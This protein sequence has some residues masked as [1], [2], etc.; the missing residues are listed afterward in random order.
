[1]GAHLASP[2]RRLGST[3]L[4]TVSAVLLLAA[5]VFISPLGLNDGAEPEPPTAADTT[6]STTATS[7]TT[8]TSPV[9]A[10][11]ST[12]AVTTSTTTV[13]TSST[14]TTAPPTTT[15]T[16]S[17]PAVFLDAAGLGIV[18]LGAPFADA[19]E[20]VTGELGPPTD[21]TGWV[22]AVSDLGTCPGTTVRVVRWNSLRLFF[23]DGPTEF[24][25]E[26]RH[27]FYYSQSTVGSDTPLLLTT[28][29]G[30]G[31]GT[32]VGELKE[33]YGSAV[34]FDLGARTGATFAITTDG[35]GLLA[36][37]VSSTGTDGAVTSIG[38]GFGCGA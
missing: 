16:T 19:V 10:P 28:T 14:S 20:A 33:V 30:V 9:S 37:T 15:P 1:M 13:P 17:P 38:G 18:D 5:L 22:A 35:P 25:E 2:R 26:T 3:V 27:L 8:S 12:A 21:D 24:G 6:T 31:L 11:P 7:T 32:T 4:A 29:T 36:G 34:Q 23:S